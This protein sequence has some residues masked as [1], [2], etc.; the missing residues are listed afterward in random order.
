M[1]KATKD[2]NSFIFKEEFSYIRKL[3]EKSDYADLE[4]ILK[5]M[6][7]AKTRL[8]ANVNFELAMELML[9]TMK[10]C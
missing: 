6:D 2:M 1:F 3:A 9:L 5:A 4:K 10:E 7:Q 8:E